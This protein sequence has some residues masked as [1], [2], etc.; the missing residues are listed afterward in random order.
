MTDV[1]GAEVGSGNAD[2][3]IDRNVALCVIQSGLLDVL[4]EYCSNLTSD[5]EDGLA[6]RSVCSD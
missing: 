2:V 3:E 4:A 5:A 1:S 6:V